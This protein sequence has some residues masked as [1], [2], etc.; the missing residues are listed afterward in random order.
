MVWAVRFLDGNPWLL[1]SR[2]PAFDSD[3]CRCQPLELWVVFYVRV[4]RG[5]PVGF[6]LH[7]HG[8][9]FWGALEPLPNSL[10]SLDKV[11][12]T[13]YSPDYI[14]DWYHPFSTSEKIA[15]E[16]IMGKVKQSPSGVCL[17]ALLVPAYAVTPICFM[18]LL[19]QVGFRTT[20]SAFH[21]CQEG[22]ASLSKI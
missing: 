21:C 15:W 13:R 3:Y 8:G 10:S 12:S 17:I 14:G 9:V 5:Y 1:H 20:N 19:K 6:F 7:K 18:N 11:G 22:I 4:G 2:I 16:W